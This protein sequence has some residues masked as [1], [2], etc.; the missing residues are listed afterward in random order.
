MKALT[1][2][3]DGTITELALTEGN[4]LA[5]LQGA[6][7]GYIEVLS[8]NERTAMVINEEGKI[9]GLP[10]NDVATRL[11][12]HY[13]IGLDPRDQI[14]GTAVLIGQTRTRETTDVPSDAEDVLTRLGFRTQKE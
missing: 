13:A 5:E 9:Y 6:V 11:T 1:I 7:G 2:T 12:Q 14:N 8:L 10:A 4:S 3:P